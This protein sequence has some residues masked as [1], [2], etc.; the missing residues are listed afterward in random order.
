MVLR[1][2]WNHSAITVKTR[3]DY[4]EIG[5]RM[6][7]NRQPISPQG[8]NKQSIY[9][10]TTARFT[11]AISVSAVRKPGATALADERKD[12][13]TTPLACEDTGKHP[14]RRAVRAW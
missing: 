6:Q 3:D 13:G 14:S 7:W 11:S 8:R 9:K 10:H 1:L 5:R 4:S 12:G 2:R